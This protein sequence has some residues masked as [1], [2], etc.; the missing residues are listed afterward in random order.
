MNFNIIIII[1]MLF[2]NNCKSEKTMKMDN[3]S[4]ACSA[5]CILGGA[6]LAKRCKQKCDSRF[7]CFNKI[8]RSRY[9]ELH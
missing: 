4:T 9:F 8:N 6:H 5:H 2:S 3:S 7:Y 1:Y